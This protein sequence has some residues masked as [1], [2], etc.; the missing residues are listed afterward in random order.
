MIGADGFSASSCFL[1]YVKAIPKDLFTDKPLIYSRK[2]KGYILYSLG[3]NMK[4]DGGVSR[5]QADSDDFDIVVR[6]GQK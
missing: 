5:E 3:P 1:A 6:V 2:G 4:D